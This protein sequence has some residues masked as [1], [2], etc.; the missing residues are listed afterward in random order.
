MGFYRILK[1]QQVHWRLVK[2][3]GVT[4]LMMHSGQTPEVQ[5][6]PVLHPRAS[7]L[8]ILMTYSV[9]GSRRIH[10]VPTEKQQESHQAPRE[11]HHSSSPT[12][13]AIPT[14]E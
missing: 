9:T 2:D 1:E 3:G 12:A 4:L 10:S 6:V 14:R 8:F 13:P 5:R 7:P 11:V